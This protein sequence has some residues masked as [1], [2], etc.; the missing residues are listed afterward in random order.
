MPN[1][2]DHREALGRN[3]T[4]LEHSDPQFWSSVNRRY[5]ALQGSDG[6]PADKRRLMSDIG[7]WANKFIARADWDEAKDHP[8]YEAALAYHGIISCE[9][10]A[11]LTVAQARGQNFGAP[12]GGNAWVNAQT[13]L[14][15]QV[16]APSDRLCTRTPHGDEPTVGG[17]LQAMLT[18]AK[19]P[20]IRAAL[21]EGT[22]SA[23]GFSIPL[24]VLPQFI[25]RLRARTQFVQ[26][27]AQ[28]VMLDGM[29]TR[30]MRTAADPVPTWRAENAAVNES[31]PT[32][33]AVDLVP[34]SLACLVK[35]SVELLQDSVNVAAALEQA[36]TGALSVELDR[37]CLFG[38]GA[39]Q[40]PLGVF[41][42]AGINTFSMGANGA[43]PTNYDPLIDA[44]YE[45][46]LDNA[47]APTA[48]IWHPRT[49]RT[50]RKL[51]DTTGQP[52]MPFPAISNL[53]LLGT[54]SVPI[55]QTQGTSTD[56]SSILVGD[57]SRAILGLRQELRIQVLNEAYMGN[58]QV[59]FVANLRADVAFERADAFCRITGVR[60]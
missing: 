19:T 53:P 48:A 47:D 12:T 30:I 34:K 60:P 2:Q 39:A 25:D 9:L 58:L 55:N 4:R 45:L 27:G 6:H 51:K 26:A 11:Q 41:N 14:P 57:F 31:D 10:D 13:G 1:I 42:Q 35:V 29:R 20:D 7:A 49:A 52:V 54:T 46:E 36:L 44:L 3:R 40:Q 15:V 59:G 24:T 18:G 5:G 21:S 16:L 33:D 23:G 8:V 43:T 38:S 37:A 22:D 56:C 17:L 28:T 50:M 32:F